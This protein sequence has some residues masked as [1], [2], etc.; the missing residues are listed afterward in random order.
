MYHPSEGGEA[1]DASRPA[2]SDLLTPRSHHGQGCRLDCLGHRRPRLD[3]SGQ[4]GVRRSV[5]CA[6]FCA[7]YTR[8]ARILREMRRVFNSLKG[9]PTALSRC[10]G[11][12]CSPVFERCG[13]RSPTN[14]RDVAYEKS[15][16][17]LFASVACPTKRYHSIGVP[18]RSRADAKFDG[19]GHLRVGLVIE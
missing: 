5:A 17:E 2:G 8:K 6:G 14:T 9:Y 13:R 11:A 10:A 12:I 19:M 16:R 1:R 18:Q 7:T 3:D 4:I 15:C